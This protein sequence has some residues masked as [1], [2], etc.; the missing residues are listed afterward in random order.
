MLQIGPWLSVKHTFFF[1][2]ISGFSW[3]EGHISFYYFKSFKFSSYDEADDTYEET[4][5]DR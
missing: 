5:E 1:T 3:R 4:I 2:D